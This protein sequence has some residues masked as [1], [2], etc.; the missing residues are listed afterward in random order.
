M[1]RRLP[2][3]SS[4]EWHRVLLLSLAA[5]CCGSKFLQFSITHPKH[6]A[7]FSYKCSFTIISKFRAGMSDTCYPGMSARTGKKIPSPSYCFKN[8]FRQEIRAVPFQTLITSKSQDIQK[9]RRHQAW[10]HGGNEGTASILLPAINH[11]NRIKSCQIEGQKAS[12]RSILQCQPTWVPF[13]TR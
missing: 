8:Q 13:V 1:E 11:R 6:L 12:Y 9:R 7:H 2:S 4:L 5:P 3:S 10:V